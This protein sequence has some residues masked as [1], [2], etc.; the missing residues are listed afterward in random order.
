[1]WS[2]GAATDVPAPAAGGTSPGLEEKTERLDDVIEKLRQQAFLEPLPPLKLAIPEAPPVDPPPPSRPVTRP[3][4]APAPPRVRERAPAAPPPPG[5]KLVVYGE[6]PPPV[7]APARAA[8]RPAPPE[9]P[10]PVP[11]AA[12]RRFRGI[13]ITLIITAIVVLFGAILWVLISVLK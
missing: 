10:A 6:A 13:G 8:S 7:V 12:A 11:A 1:V 2:G 4:T 5:R 9:A 3:E